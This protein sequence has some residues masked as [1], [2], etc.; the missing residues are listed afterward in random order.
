M[1]FKPFAGSKQ[2]RVRRFESK[3]QANG[4]WPGAATT[5]SAFYFPVGFE[6]KIG[7]VQIRAEGTGS[8]SG[9]TQVDV[10]VNGTSLFSGSNRFSI[11]SADTGW[12]TQQGP[13]TKTGVRPGDVVS[14]HVTGTPATSGHQNVSF[15]IHFV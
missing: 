4:F 3:L 12:F 10:R 15:A 11:A 1:A 7:A 14:L 6:G 5:S 2:A 9:N 8:G 13:L